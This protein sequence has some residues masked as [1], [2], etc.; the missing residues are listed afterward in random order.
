V[1][2]VSVLSAAAG[3]SSV[4]VL[5]ATPNTLARKSQW[6]PDF[7]AGASAGLF[8]GAG[9]WFSISWA[10]LDATG[11]GEAFGAA[12]AEVGGVLADCDLDS[13]DAADAVDVGC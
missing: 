13:V 9:F 10:F 8:W 12:A 7:F 5:P 6:L 3:L 4:F 11:A 2:T 1:V